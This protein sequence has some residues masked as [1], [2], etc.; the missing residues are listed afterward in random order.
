MKLVVFLRASELINGWTHDKNAD[1]LKCDSLAWPE[2]LQKALEVLGFFNFFFFL[3]SKICSP[4]SD[5]H[6]KKEASLFAS[7]RHKQELLCSGNKSLPTISH[8]GQWLFP[9][10]WLWL[11]GARSLHEYVF[12]YSSIHSFIQQIH[13]KHLLDARH[14]YRHL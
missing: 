2:V 8:P 10:R 7:A 6:W 11:L 3:M 12:I 1:V 9:W 14:S 5:W 4:F 13:I